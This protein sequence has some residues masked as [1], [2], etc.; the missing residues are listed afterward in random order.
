MLAIFI[1]LV[2]VGVARAAGATTT[3]SMT[4]ERSVLVVAVSVAVAKN[5]LSG[6]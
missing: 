4:Y 2:S 3:W 6:H 5:V 1:A